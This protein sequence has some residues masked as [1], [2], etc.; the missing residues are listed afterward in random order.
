MVVLFLWALLFNVL[1]NIIEHIPDNTGKISF[2]PNPL[3]DHPAI[4]KLTG[5]TISNISKP[6]PPT[7]KSKEV[8][9]SVKEFMLRY[10]LGEYHIKIILSILIF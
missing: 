3:M 8:L 9:G 6:I 7:L 10:F 5:K 1:K 2:I 4:K